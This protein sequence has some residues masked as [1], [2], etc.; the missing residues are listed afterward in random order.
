MTIQA[1]PSSLPYPLA[2]HFDAV[3]FDMDGVLVQSEHFFFWK[4]AEREVFSR[5]GIHITEQM[6]KATQSMTTAEAAG[7]APISSSTICAS[8]DVRS[9]KCASSSPP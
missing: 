7:S 2:Q 4:R 8:P 5:I 3:I 9:S 6:S 1:A